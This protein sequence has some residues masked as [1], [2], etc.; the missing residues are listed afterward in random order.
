MVCCTYILL[1]ADNSFYVGYTHDL[2]AR[3]RAHQLQRGAKH[4][5]TQGATRLIYFEQHATKYEAIARERQ[6][7]KWSRAKKIALINGNRERLRLL[8]KSRD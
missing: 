4:T 3:F 2:D 1:C 7:K 6:I 5:A 8:S